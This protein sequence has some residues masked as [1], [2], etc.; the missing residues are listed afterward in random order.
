MFCKI[1]IIIHRSDVIHVILFKSIYLKN[2]NVFKHYWQVFC[3]K[4]NFFSHLFSFK[5]TSLADE[6]DLLSLG[7]LYNV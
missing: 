6:I 4:E 7:S 3:E 1:K 2:R 5:S